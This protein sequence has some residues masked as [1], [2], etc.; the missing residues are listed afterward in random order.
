MSPKALLL[1]S[2]EISAFD[3]SKQSVCSLR[4]FIPA[5]ALLRGTYLELAGRIEQS[6][7]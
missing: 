6:R 4:S 3:T 2:I 1:V 5:L 7:F